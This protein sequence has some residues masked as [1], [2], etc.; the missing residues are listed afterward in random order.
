[1]IRL[2][3][4]A[5]IISE[6]RALITDVDNLNLVESARSVFAG[7]ASFLPELDQIYKFENSLEL[8]DFV[9]LLLQSLLVHQIRKL[10]FQLAEII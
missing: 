5:H 4:V 3:F 2:Q 6:G 9:V 10:I 1:M 8:P 7:L